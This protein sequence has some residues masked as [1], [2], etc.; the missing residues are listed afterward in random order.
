LSTDRV[1]GQPELRRVTL[2]QI[3]TKQN[4]IK[5]NKTKQKTKTNKRQFRSLGIPSDSFTSLPCVFFLEAVKHMVGPQ[6]ILGAQT[7]DK[8]SFTPSL[9]LGS[10]D[11]RTHLWK[12]NTLAV[13]SYSD[14]GSRIQ[15]YE[16]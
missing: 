1:S 4:K 8:T 11:D 5:Q 7:A 13:Q 15:D 10:G 6:Y 9:C 12:G 2:S 3:K 14:K 16:L